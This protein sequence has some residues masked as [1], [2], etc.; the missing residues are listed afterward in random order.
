MVAKVISGKNIRGVLNYNEQKVL[1][2]KAECIMQHLFKD[3]VTKLSFFDKLN[4]FTDLN[5]RNKR[6]KTNTLHISLNF[7]VSEKI[8]VQQLNAI[9][10]TYMNRIGFNDQPYLVYEHKDAAHQHVH[11]VTTIIK[12]DGKRIPIHYLG[13]NQSETARKQIEKEFNL[14]VAEKQNK[15]N[16]VALQP[17][18]VQKLVYGK[19]ATK[20]GISTIVTAVARTY[21]FTSLPEFNAV[22]RQFNVVAE[23][24]HENSNMYKKNGLLYSL[25]DDRGE[26]IGIPIKASALLGK[27]MISY[28]DK[29]YKLN[30]VLRQPYKKKLQSTIDQTLKELSHASLDNFIKAL[31]KKNINT[32]L[33][34]NAEGRI[35]GITFVDNKSKVVFNGSTLGKPYSAT[36]LT[37]R[38]HKSEDIAQHVR[39]AYQPTGHVE[40]PS[41]S[42]GNSLLQQLLQ[43]EEEF[44]GSTSLR[45]R[46]KK[47]RRRP[48]N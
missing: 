28:L 47:R 25:I 27:P 45:L 1:E 38:L 15:S 41:N 26:R 36:A 12:H 16:E 33:R 5:N 19:T 22:L 48:R 43:P 40:V 44:T 6:T 4:R 30:E 35:Y 7:D 3:E 2:G 20:K 24:G 32:V 34:I 31:H 18:D 14:V 29:Q 17:I 37:G 42:Q 11:I 8:T 23:R 10:S 13:K 21:K 9:A 46:K 39:P